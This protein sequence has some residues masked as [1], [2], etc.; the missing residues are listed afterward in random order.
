MLQDGVYAPTGQ[1]DSGTAVLTFDGV[2][3]EVD[4]DALLA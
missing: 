3:V 1:F 4:I 2:E